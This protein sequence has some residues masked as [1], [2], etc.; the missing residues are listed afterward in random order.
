VTHQQSSLSFFKA[1]TQKLVLQRLMALGFLTLGLY[2]WAQLLGALKT[3]EPGFFSLTLQAQSVALF[4][5]VANLVAAVGL[6][7]TATWGAVVWLSAAAAR[8]VRHTVFAA[9]LG[10][11]PV[12]T[13]SEVGLILLYGLLTWLVTRADRR[14]IRRQHETRRSRARG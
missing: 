7:L 10:W 1:A 6:W 3:P 12:L 11:T 4:F 13:G 2:Q 14:E 9:S 8:I 5:A